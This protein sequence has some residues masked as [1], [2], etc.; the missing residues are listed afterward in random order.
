M[1]GEVVAID[2]GVARWAALSDGTFLEGANAFKKYE[3]RLATPQQKLARCM[4]FSK[5]WLKMKRKITRLHVKIGNIRKDQLH[6]ASSTIS[7]NHAIAIKEDLR[8]ANMTASAKGTLDN[9]APMWRRKPALTGASKAKAGANW[10][11]NSTTRNAGRAACCYASIHVIRTRWAD[12]SLRRDGRK[13][14]N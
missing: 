3:A 10:I 2:L 4:P 5:N 8:V 9:P 6:K 7:K 1:M 14:L 11:G 13:I 12:G